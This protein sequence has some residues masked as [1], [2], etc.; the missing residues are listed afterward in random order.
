MGKDYQR[1]WRGVAGAANPSSALP[2]FFEI[3]GDD[4]YGEGLMFLLS[5]KGE[6]AETCLALLDHVSHDPT[7]SPFAIQ[8]VL[9]V[10]VRWEGE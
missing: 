2:W 4:P 8:V 9:S 7:Y 6:D 10:H 5:L 3:R 1:L